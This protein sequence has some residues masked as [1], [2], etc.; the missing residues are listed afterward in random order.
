MGTAALLLLC[1]APAQAQLVN[2]D[3]SAGNTG[4]TT[5]YPVVTANGTVHT[6]PPS[7]NTVQNPSVAFTNGYTSYTDHT[8]DAAALMLFVDGEADTSFWGETPTLAANT[9]Y[10]FSF[11]ATGADSLN[12]S[13]LQFS[14]NGTNIGSDHQLT[15][16][17]AWVDYTDQFTTGSA[18]TYSLSLVDLNGIQNG[19]DF[20]VD[21]IA[22]GGGA[23][24]VPEPGSWAL[25]LIGFLGVAALVR[26]QRHRLISV[27]DALKVRS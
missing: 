13:D 22:L 2:G 1:A 19:N 25:M 6:N 8:G 24:G 21:D 17:G 23:G 12:L 11:W 3:F 26:F 14:V 10:T 20:T 9:T 4:F 16:T 7:Y 15:T 18:G 27:Q 5:G